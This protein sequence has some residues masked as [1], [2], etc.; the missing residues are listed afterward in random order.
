MKRIIVLFIVVMF[1]G[2]LS[3]QNNYKYAINAKGGITFGLKSLAANKLDSAIIRG[4]SI[5]FYQGATVI[6]AATGGGSATGAVLLKDSVNYASGYMSRMDG[7]VGL[8]LKLNT[9]DSS[10][11]EDGHFAKD[12]QQS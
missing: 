8:G 6:K 3:A 4:D 7:V 12:L 5:I 10:S 1:A 9:A 11:T 2:L